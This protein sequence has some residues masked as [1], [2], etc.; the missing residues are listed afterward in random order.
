MRNLYRD[1]EHAGLFAAVEQAADG[2]VVTDTT[3]V[4]EYVNPAFTA[5][6][7]YT[8]EEALGK[9]TRILKSGRNP[10]SLYAEL[11]RTI[12]AGNPWHGEMTNV[13]K[14]GTHYIEEMRIAPV[15]D[16][17]DQITGYIAIKHD[18]TQRNALREAHAFLAAVVGNSEDAI[19]SA[20]P[21]G[22]I[23]TWNCG[24]ESLTGLEPHQAIGEHF[25][26]CVP[27]DRV[28]S[29][30][31][32]IAQTA[33]GQPVRDHQGICKHTDGHVVPVS[34]TWFP[35]RDPQGRI[36]AIAAILRDCTER[37]ETE[38]KLR[39]SQGRFREAF[40]FAPVSMWVTGMDG[41]LKQVN[42]AFC[43]TLGYS[44]PELLNKTWMDICHPDDLQDS[45]ERRR[46]LWN[47]NCLTTEEERRY[48]RRDGTVLWCEVRL[49]LVRDIHGSPLYC[50]GHGVDITERKRAQ[51]ALSESEERFQSM[52]DAC[53]SMMWVADAGGKMQ[54]IN[55]AFREFC[56]IT[57]EQAQAGNWIAVVHPEDVSGAY[58]SFVRTVK[59]HTPF[60]T[61][62]RMLRAD[63]QWRVVGTRAQP[64]YSPDG[65]FMGHIGLCADIT[66][67]K[68]SDAAVRA[69]QEF[70]QSTIDALSSHIC[71]TDA[72]GTIIAVN[73]A[74]KEFAT[75]NCNDDSAGVR[76]RVP[77]MERV[78]IGANY[79]DVCDRANSNGAGE[80]ADFAKG[81]RS[82]VKGLSTTFSAEYSC[83]SPS[84]A[85]WF[86]GKVTQ[87]T[88]NGELRVVIEHIN[89]TERKRVE[90]YLLQ[91]K[92]EAEAESR[93]REFQN[94]LISAILDV[95][96]DGILVV[97]DGVIV[98]ENEKFWDVWQIDPLSVF[99]ESPDA[100]I[101]RPDKLLLSVAFERV[102]NLDSFLPRVDELYADPSAE[103]HCEI[104]L[105]D[106]RILERHSTSLY[107]ERG[108]HSARVWFFRDITERKSAE[109]SLRLSEARLRGITDSAQDAIL[110]IDP[111]GKI[112]YWNPAAEIVFGY[113][114]EEAI[115]KSLHHLLTSES[116][117]VAHERA[118]P[119]FL[120]TG[121]GHAVGK[122]LELIGRRKDGRDIC[123]DLSLSGISLNNEWNAIGILRDVTQRKRDELALQNSEEKF[124][125]LAENIREAFWM[126]NADGTNILYISPAYEQIWG[127]S[128][129]QLY[130][131]PLLWIDTVHPD[132]RDCARANSL[133]Q[134]AGESVDAEYRILTPNGQQKWIRNRAFPIRDGAG[135]VIRV[136]GLSED[137]TEWKRHEQALI[138]ARIDADAASLAK[139]RFL[140]TMSHEIRTPM[141][142]VMGMNQLLLETELTP[143]QRRFV[144]VAQESGKSLLAIIDDVLDLSK[145]E[146][147]ML[148]L[149]NLIF[150]LP[151]V[152]KNVVAT[153]SVL[154]IAKGLRFDTRVS[155]MIPRLVFGDAQRLR[156]VLTNLCGNA[157]KFTATGG[158]SLDAELYSRLNGTLTIRFT[159][160]D[161]GIGIDPEQITKLFSPFV[162]ADS[163]TTR[164]YGGTGLGLAISKELVEMMGGRIEVTSQKGSGSTFSFTTTFGDPSAQ[165]VESQRRADPIALPKLRLGLA[166]RRTILVAEDNATNRI[167]ILAQLA[168][169]GYKA[170]AVV[171]GLE[172]VEAVQRS[173]YDLV[174]MDCEM[175]V[176][177]GYE[178][179]HRIRE[180]VQ[181][182]IPIIALTANAMVSDRERCLQEGMDEHLA[183]PVELH[184]L[185]ALLDKWLPASLTV[186]ED[187][188]HGDSAKAPTT[189]FDSQSFLRRLMGDRQLAQ[190]VLDAFA[191]DAPR[192]LRQITARLDQADARGIALQAHSLQG[193]A[194]T[195]AANSLQ[196][197]V[198]SIES[199]AK[200]GL[201]HRCRDQ[202]L[203]ANAALDHFLTRAKT[204]GWNVQ[205]NDNPTTEESDYVQK[206]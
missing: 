174:L 182:R 104:E 36:V 88:S 19:I 111:L 15:R 62:V 75:S 198:Q 189:I 130:N 63:G 92:L 20:T 95:S 115:G 60:S 141:N 136:A 61:E 123:V 12:S 124:R 122:T 148:T 110:M 67:R 162:Q 77:C 118:F 44:E 177:D 35:V 47:G 84:E 168:K 37:N 96:P 40:E 73:K 190:L 7:G 59:D 203:C 91:A 11:W 150:N 160:R 4:I 87:F 194:A 33:L 113:T 72:A 199:A 98:L 70:A 155:E 80:A 53:P 164:K 51:N 66:E 192:Q 42:M 142:G 186:A 85:R 108:S 1:V 58:A 176:M 56:D 23:L 21:D 180:S 79:L 107:R 26:I 175:P 64:R 172:A 54:F 39:E 143:E 147:G 134:Q 17:N 154:A 185:A 152:V 117:Q 114:N 41:Y 27:P 125:E 191:N 197:I 103:D 30:A 128:C 45:I 138:R 181:A 179:T 82:V 99:G 167:V 205:L 28:E 14:N 178:A 94:S 201:L 57:N 81:I 156:Q 132:D 13:R 151:D 55:T 135:T 71:V 195:V 86:Q 188:S 159:V 31:R 8:E 18:V 120:L 126:I 65:E 52:A 149:E 131:D 193:A 16:P 200:A 171:N 90:Q 112:S 165:D 106:G 127:R 2:V 202:I 24:A 145:I 109:L 97:D 184:G 68:L 153:S 144:Q 204:D 22:T 140:A 29:A 139:S 93:H 129:D 49:S 78:N 32:C 187:S 3:G 121:E 5:L 46:Q 196:S 89:I 170:V 169:L 206:G 38:K 48:I 116:S 43:R 101:G 183:K 69:S 83:H 133:K 146:S 9:H 173:K 100:R 105:K 34:V 10:D 102:K 166:Q 163:S 76:Q 50:V 25:S 119:K 157:V 158:V 6:T 74:W 161:T 137:I